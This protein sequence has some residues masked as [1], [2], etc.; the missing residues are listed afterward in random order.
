MLFINCCCSLTMD[1]FKGFLMLC[2]KTTSICRRTCFTLVTRVAV[3]TD[4]RVHVHTVGA[5]P[6][7][8]TRAADTL[9]HVYNIV[10]NCGNI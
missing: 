1:T 10:S 6:A 8:L 4:T 5:I 7:I 9:V 2:S 3:D